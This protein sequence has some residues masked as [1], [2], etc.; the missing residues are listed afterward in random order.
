MFEAFMTADTIK[1]NHIMA[2]AARTRTTDK[3]FIESELRRFKLS[4]IRQEML[5]GARYYEGDHD[6]RN[7]KRMAIG[8]NGE[9]EEVKNLPNY[10]VIDNQYA[11]MVK[12]KVNYLL[13]KPV[14]FKTDNEAYAEALNQFFDED[15]MRLLKNVGRD[16][17]NG[18]IGW[19]YPGYDDEGSLTFTRIRN[20]ELRPLWADNEH[21]ILDA[22][23]R[24]YLVESYKE[25]E[26]Q[27]IEKVEVYDQTG[28]WYFT[29]DGVNLVA[30]E[31]SYRPYLLSAD[32][33]EIPLKWSRIPLI[34]CKYNAEEVPL[35]RNTK[36]L[37]DGINQMLSTFENN[38]GEDSRNTIIV[39]VNYDGQ[40]L[41]EF[42]HNLSQYGAIKVR[43]DSS[44]AGGDVKT[45]Q[46]EVNAENYKA[47]VE[48]FKKAL[49]ENAMGFDAKDDRLSGSPNQM[50]IQS[51]YS[52]L[53]LDTNDFETELQA[54][55]KQI[56]WFVNAHLANTGKGDFF[57]EQVEVVFSRDIMMND[58]DTVSICKESVG[59]ISD[60]TIISK[61]PW[62]TDV[63][64]EME[65]LQQQKEKEMADYGFPAPG[66][67]LQSEGGEP[68][69]DEDEKE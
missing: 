64:A 19:L 32:G 18:S 51:M 1:L 2:E 68:I 13:G 46:I 48:M 35:I 31:V 41:G 56:L 53:D 33:T 34:P 5:D 24:T 7:A 47:I 28:I 42:R 21:T 10:R 59:L 29:R 11:R 20:Y 23:I 45:L 50:N 12:Q 27:L 17:I 26:P 67:Q 37:Q 54:M 60:E 61:H 4:Q 6:I 58:A 8:Q 49:I 69:N 25:K 63:D 66:R 44:D 65:R 40:N 30:D 3:D 15:F 36:S 38:M 55:F 39:L 57:H 22:A 43:S 62:V 52:D 9:L 14:I 16:A